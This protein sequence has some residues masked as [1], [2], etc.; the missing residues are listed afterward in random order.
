MLLS[1]LSQ[2]YAC[3]FM[4]SSRYIIDIILIKFIILLNLIILIEEKDLY[5]YTYVYM[6]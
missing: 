6:E 4:I 5:F 2:L 3:I 1:Y